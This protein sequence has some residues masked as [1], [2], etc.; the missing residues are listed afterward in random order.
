LI[1]ILDKLENT[2]A[3]GE[4]FLKRKRVWDAGSMDYPR[5]IEA[6]PKGTAIRPFSVFSYL[7]HLYGKPG[8]VGFKL[9]YSQLRQFPEILA[10]LVR[11]R[12][13]VVH[14]VRQNHLDV[15]ISGAIRAKAGRAHLLPG[16]SRPA[17]VRIELDPK[18]LLDQLG[19]LRTNIIRARRLLKWCGL[20]HIEVSYEKLTRNQAQF[21]SV[22]R[23]LSMDARGGIPQSELTRIRKE[24]HVQV[25]S[26]YDEVKKALA[27]SIFANLLE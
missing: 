26:N 12:I 13:Y 20:P 8:A 7:D 10:Y 11:H 6:R 3:Y 25:I 14:L 19:R 18:T 4:L 23:F 1:S 15:L 5:F 16:Q 24:G 27:G 17:D 2:S 22:L 21:S 9:M